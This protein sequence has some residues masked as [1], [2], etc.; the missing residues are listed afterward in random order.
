MTAE[1]GATAWG[2]AWLR[3][4]EPVA[5][6][7]DRLRP[8]ARSLARNHAVTSLTIT[9]GQVEAE[10]AGHRTSLRLPSGTTPN[11]SNAWWPRPSTTPDRWR[12]ATSPT[13]WPPR[14]A[15]RASRSPYPRTP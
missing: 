4:A 5:A 6:P 10:V 11:A 7:P 12:R 3:T 9:A 15:P 8:K 14:S 1:F 2:R 13:T